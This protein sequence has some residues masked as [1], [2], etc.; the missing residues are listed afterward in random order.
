MP[1]T[2]PVAMAIAGGASA[3]TSI[4]STRAA[5]RQN[6]RAMDANERADERE[7]AYARERDEANRRERDRRWQEYVS[8][9]Q[10]HWNLGNQVLGNLYDLAGM[11]Q[12]EGA[13]PGLSD[14]ASAVRDAT[15]GTPAMAGP[16]AGA[17]GAPA[18]LAE[19]GAMGGGPPSPSA[20]RP[21]SARRNPTAE[22]PGQRIDPYQAVRSV[23]SLAE[24]AGLAGGGRRTPTPSIPI[25]GFGQPATAPALG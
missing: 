11:A 14:P 10:P 18:T 2:I 7:L 8:L 3:A 25:P 16:V 5:S 23:L 20:G 24:L 4:Y 12:P 15:S 19:M 13:G 21:F 22:R 6:E 17:G 9:R 1:I